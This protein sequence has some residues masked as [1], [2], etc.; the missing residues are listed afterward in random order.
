MSLLKRSLL[1]SFAFA[2]VL[3]A[4]EFAS[5][6]R[7]PTPRG[8]Q[9]AKLIQ[10]VGTTDISVT[11]SRPAVKGRVVYG[12]WPWFADAINRSYITGGPVCLCGA[13]DRFAASGVVQLAV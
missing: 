2:F 12:D 9:K 1:L 6:Q 5:G 11:Y 7:P 10:T 3:S 8:S 4:V 13:F